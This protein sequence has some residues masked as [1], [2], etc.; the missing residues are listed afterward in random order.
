MHEIAEF[1]SA[2]PP[3]DTLAEDELAAVAA[4]TEIEFIAAS[5]D[6]RAGRGR[7]RAR[8]GGA[9][10]NGR[11]ADGSRVVDLLVRARCSGTRRC[12]PN[13]RP[14]WACAHEDTLCYRIPEAVLRPVPTTPRTRRRSATG[15]DELEPHERCKPDGRWPATQARRVCGDGPGAHAETAQ[16][17]RT[18][19]MDGGE[20][21]DIDPG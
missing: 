3:F 8:L 2:N 9:A 5:D 16:E 10:W 15:E 19:V 1:L 6:P 18:D 14:P 7:A 11:A 12:S 21:V 20:R 17:G 4:A 13:G